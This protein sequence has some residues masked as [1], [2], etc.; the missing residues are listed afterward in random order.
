MNG[1]EISITTDFMGSQG[2]PR[3]A[4]RLIAGAGIKTVHWCHRYTGLYL[5]DLPETSYIQSL[6][7]EFDLKV[8]DVHA[9]DGGREGILWMSTYTSERIIGM[10]LIHN[11]MAF[12]R[13]IGARAIVLHVSKLLPEDPHAR[14]EY[15][16]LAGENLAIIAGWAEDLNVK[17]GLENTDS[18]PDN[19]QTILALLEISNPEWI[20]I[21]YDS[22]HGN[23]HGSIDDFLEVAKNRL[24]VLHLNDNHGPNGPGESGDPD[25]HLLPFDGSTDWESVIEVIGRSAY[26]G[27][28]NFEVS[29]AQYKDEMSREEFL[30]K[31]VLQASEVAR[32]AID[33]GATNLMMAD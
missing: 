16:R 29:Y 4:L 13:V 24:F 31:F 30:D 33:A 9:S 11:R 17:V 14:A 32:L 5:Y 12:A 3:E 1:V 26:S 22:G 8:L 21:T 7:V 15:L 10:A 19:T 6:L 23:I 25:I 28:L 27:P 18:F 2:D 20:G